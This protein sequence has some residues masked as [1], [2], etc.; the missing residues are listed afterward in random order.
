MPLLSDR[1]LNM[2][3]GVMSSGAVLPRSRVSCVPRY[4][5]R[6]RDGR[7]DRDVALKALPEVFT[8]RHSHEEPGEEEATAHKSG[9]QYSDSEYSLRLRPLPHVVTTEDHHNEPGRERIHGPHP[10]AR[11][12]PVAS[13]GW[14]IESGP[15]ERV[16]NLKAV[17][18]RVVEVPD[19]RLVR[20]QVDA[21][22]RRSNASRAPSSSRG[23]S[24]QF[25]CSKTRQWTNLMANAPV[26]GEL[27][28][29]PATR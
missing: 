23:T 3:R 1:F 22:L 27:L 26:G 11:D 10:H 17:P 6:A 13:A 8:S 20:V 25:G 12:D 28:V 9:Q 14:L 4:R 16:K 21:D 18:G 29:R 7:L 15:A 5:G 2:S 24:Q 19:E